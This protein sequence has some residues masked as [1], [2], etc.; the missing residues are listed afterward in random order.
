MN[1][2]T[3]TV[4]FQKL[5]SWG[6]GR[7]FALLWLTVS[8]GCAA[9]HPIKGLPASYL[10]QEYLG[11][12]RDGLRPINPMLLTRARPA[13][14]LVDAGDVLSVYIPSVLGLKSAGLDSLGD[15][16]PI[17]YPSDPE[18]PPT[19]GYP[20]SV[21]DDGTVS[22]PQIS[23][24]PVRGLTV[25]Q[26]EQAIRQA[27]TAPRQV[28]NIDSQ[29]IVVSLQRIR[30]YRVLVVREDSSLVSATTSGQGQVNLGNTRRGTARIVSLKAYENDVL[31]ALA[32]TQGADGLPGLD[33][34]G[35]VYVIRRQSRGGEMYPYSYGNPIPAGM[36]VGIAGRQGRP[37]VPAM[38][39]AN[40]RPVVRYQSP[41]G[42]YRSGGASNYS[43]HSF[44]SM[45]TTAA[46][47]GRYGAPAMTS[48]PPAGW[49]P[50]PTPMTGMTT[51]RYGQMPA[52]GGR[53]PTGNWS[54]VNPVGLAGQS[55][56]GQRPMQPQQIQLTQAHLEPLPSNVQPIPMGMPTSMPSSP[57]LSPPMMTGPVGSV[58]TNTGTTMAGPAWTA[59]AAQYSPPA[60]APP[61]GP[62]YVASQPSFATS[63][64]GATAPMANSYGVMPTDDYFDSMMASG[65]DGTIDGPNVIRIPIRVGP[66]EVPQISE[67]DVIL[68]DGDIVFIEARSSEVFYTGGL[69]GGGQFTL[70]RD[71]D[72][73]ALEALSIAQSQGTRGGGGRSASAGGV[74]A[75]NQDV[76]ISASKLIVVRKLGD[77]T[78][79]PIE[80]DLTRAKQDM[81]GRENIVIQP[82]DYLYLQYSCI[83]AVGA[84]FERHLLEGA[85]FGLATSQ[86]NRGG[87]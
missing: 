11:P 50:T 74:S 66:G 71:Y 9:L 85:L 67:Q 5:R 49:S 33:A 16:P 60:Y 68:E 14:H 38:A 20:V 48:P 45:K 18:M 1:L 59:P 40:A 72:L 83:E 24:L 58:P 57:S 55:P 70:P 25:G 46:V 10:P 6:A 81:T 15:A 61:A 8:C 69:L 23:P 63:S 13:E 84:F 3:S 64:W 12:S 30:D 29:R 32:R 82:G 54:T 22:L 31:H 87:N 80:V 52:T 7:L 62:Q 37:P 26:V 78:S 28:I 73:R 86:F 35:A 39:T 2:K 51:G 34:E 19:I 76:T 53:N 65:L 21:R 44:S 27:Y 47:S 42:N 79:V 4:G 75:L 43:G 36:P 17:N 41:D 77:G 56:Y